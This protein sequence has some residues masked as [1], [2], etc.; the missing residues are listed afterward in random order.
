MCPWGRR[1]TADRGAAL[2]YFYLS[3]R[4]TLSR[5]LDRDLM[6]E[7]QRRAWLT[8]ITEVVMAHIRAKD[9][10]E[11]SEPQPREHP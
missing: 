4:Y 9:G 6:A 7:D 5:F 1:S 10:A 3:N 2:G 8:H 11:R